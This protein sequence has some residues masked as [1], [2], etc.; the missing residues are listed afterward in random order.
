LFEIAD[1]L[2]IPLRNEII[3]PRFTQLLKKRIAGSH[4]DKNEPE[5]KDALLKLNLSQMDILIKIRDYFTAK[6]YISPFSVK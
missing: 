3:H 4:K 2:K 1:T 6:L 5:I